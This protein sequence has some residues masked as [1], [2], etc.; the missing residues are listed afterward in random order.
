VRHWLNERQADVSEVELVRIVLVQPK[1][2]ASSL[3]P[4][5]VVLEYKASYT[6]IVA[7][8]SRHKALT[9]L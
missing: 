4:H 2:S 3:Y 5:A 6:L 8:S 9:L 1:S 7:P